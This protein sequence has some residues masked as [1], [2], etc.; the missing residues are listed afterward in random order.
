MEDI[1][2]SGKFKLKESVPLSKIYP[3]Y[4]PATSDGKSIDPSNVWVEVW[5]KK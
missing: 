2:N 4:A 5:V 3:H 1:R